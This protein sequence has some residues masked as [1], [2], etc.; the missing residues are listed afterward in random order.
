V[1]ADTVVPEAGNPQAL[2]RYSYTLNNPLKYTD[3]S[4]HFFNLALAAGG[5][6]GGAVIGAI[7]AAGPQIIQNIQSGQPLTANIDPTQV[8]QAAVAGAVAGAIGGATF[9][10]GTA[11]MGTGLGATVA[12]GAL[13][14]AIAG[15]V[16]RAAE[17]V[18]TGQDITTGL[19]DPGDIAK[20]A[21]VGGALAGVGY[22]AGRLVRPAVAEATSLDPNVIGRAGEEA[23]GITGPKTQIRSLTGTANYRVPDEVVRSAQVLREVKNVARL[24]YTSQLRDY[25]LYS[26]QEGYTFELITRQTTQLSGPLQAAIERGEIIWRHLPW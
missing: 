2:N 25:A 6:V 15:Q 8:A 3:P 21:V 11:V 13:S 10:V 12:S 9:G 7:F 1:Q 14:G 22:G 24:S 18:L 23:A 20:E 4:G 16:G 26:Q 17:N 19:G 5:A